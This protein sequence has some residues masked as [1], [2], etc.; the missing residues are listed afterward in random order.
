MRATC[1]IQSRSIEAAST[2]LMAIYVIACLP[3]N[4]T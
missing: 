1:R 2:V 4:V 3:Q